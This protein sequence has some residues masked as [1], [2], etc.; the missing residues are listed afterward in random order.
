MRESEDL[1]EEFVH[2]ALR[3]VRRPREVL[4][5]LEPDVDVGAFGERVFV[6]FVVHDGRLKEEA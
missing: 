6:R 1:A 5:W 2:S 3:V 4:E